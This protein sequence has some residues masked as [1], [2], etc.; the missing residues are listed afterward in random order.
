MRALAREA[1]AHA[2][3]FGADKDAYLAEAR[4]VLEEKVIERLATLT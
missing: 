3:V 4:R 2:G 1:F